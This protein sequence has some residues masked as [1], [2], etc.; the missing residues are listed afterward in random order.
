MRRPRNALVAL[1]ALFAFAAGAG[2]ADETITT[3]NTAFNLPNRTIAVGDKVTWTNS[4]QGFHNVRSDDAG[5]VC[6]NG[7]NGEGGNGGPSTA[8]WSFT[9]TF[10]TAGSFVY[11]CEIHGDSSSGMRG[12]ITVEGA[13]GG[14]GGGGGGGAPGSLKFSASNYNVNEGGG[15]VTLVVQRVGGDDG[16]V[17]VH[18]AT[19]NGSA[20]AGAD[21]TAK[22]GNINWANNDDN[23]KTVSIAITNDNTPESAETFTVTLSAPGGGATLG[24][25]SAATVTIVGGGAPAAPAAPD[26]LKAVAQSGTQIQLNWT[27]HANNET[28]FVIEKRDD[29]N[30]V[31]ER[32]VIGVLHAFNK[33]HGDDFNDEDVRLL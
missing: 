30:R 32:T 25:P 9:R 3:A 26:N 2:R 19:S 28:G 4:S 13:G 33:R 8:L 29:E 24:S 15:N 10:N 11:W 31:V 6:A 5:F 7:C 20:T 16:A 27:D 18:Y 17:S 12:V 21:Y 23:N 22:S 14:G 1:W